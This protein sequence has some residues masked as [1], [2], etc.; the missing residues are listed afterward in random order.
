MGLACVRR[1]RIVTSLR[2]LQLPDRLRSRQAR[3]L[4][5]IITVPFSGR[6]GCVT[7]LHV[8]PA[9]MPLDRKFNAARDRSFSVEALRFL[10]GSERFHARQGTREHWPF[11][12]PLSP[13][14]VIIL[15]CSPPT[16]LSWTI[17]LVPPDSG[18]ELDSNIRYYA[19]LSL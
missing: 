7:G 5:I 1:C 15:A 12:V 18:D 19:P 16:N 14:V 9:R 8:L 17:F 10:S 13:L 11:S 4:T 3:C 6:N 2:Q